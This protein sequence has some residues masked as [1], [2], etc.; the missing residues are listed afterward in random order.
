MNNLWGGLV[1]DTAKQLNSSIAFDCRMWREDITGSLAHAKMLAHQGIISQADGEAIQN[2]LTSILNDIESGALAI[3]MSAEDIHTFVE[4]ELTKRIGDAGKRLHTARSRND[5]VATD[6]RLYL[7]GQ[8]DETISLVHDLVAAL[9]EQAAA[10]ADT[11]MPGYTH[12]QRAQPVTLGHY[13]CAYAMMLVRDAGRLSDA[14][15][16][17]NQCPLGACALAG[18][19]FPTDRT[20][21]AKELGFD[22]PCLNSLDA[23]SDRDFCV[24]LMA[25]LSLLMAHLSRFSE[26]LVLWSSLEFH[27]VTLPEGFVTGSSIMPQKKNPDMAELIRGKTGRVYGDLTTM[28]TVLKGLPLAYN[29]DLQEDKE[30]VFD[31][32]DTAKLCL[33]VM[34]PMIGG[35]TVHEDSMRKA[36]G[37]GFINA[38]DCADWLVAHGVPFRE[39]YGIAA[40]LVHAGTPLEDVTL[41]EYK[42]ACPVFDETI[43]EA[44]NLDN[45]V[46]R[47][48]LPVAEQIAFLD[49][50]LKK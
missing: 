13:L 16:R 11:V 7:R 12:L 6:L 8:I 15:V 18:T 33:A 14:R 31:A 49:E 19:T 2:G 23:V 26:E 4:M 21:T 28:L 43:Y 44:I 3:D 34:A 9:K 27:F 30:A 32:L 42:K 39:A 46:K 38:T 40:G 10:H 36:A 48:N 24:E 5:Q 37:T 45:C 29:K 47:R 50:F 1:A 41:D 25:D 20:M 35:M 17:L 22:G